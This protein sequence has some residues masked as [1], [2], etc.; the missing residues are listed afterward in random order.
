[1]IPLGYVAKRNCEPPPGLGLTG[2]VDIYSVSDCVNDNFAE[3]VN[4]WKHNGYWFF[5]SPELIRQVARENSINLKGTKLF[6]YEAHE[7]EFDGQRWNPLRYLASDA[8]KC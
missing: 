3:Y 5:D 1:M 6:Y 2:V 8:A 4:Y 7:L